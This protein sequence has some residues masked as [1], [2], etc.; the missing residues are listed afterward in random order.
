MRIE[1]TDKPTEYYTPRRP[2]QRCGTS[3]RYASNRMCVQCRRVYDKK[4]DDNR[5]GTRQQAYRRIRS[6]EKSSWLEHLPPAMR[7]AFLSR[8][9]P[10][11]RV[12]GESFD[13]RE[14]L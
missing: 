7:D 13:K 3:R 14:T 10:N 9:Y 5:M 8:E 4:R 12:I 6:R 11:W 2:C 1:R